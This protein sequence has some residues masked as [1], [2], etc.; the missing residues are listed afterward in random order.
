MFP[1]IAGMCHTLPA[2]VH[3]RDGNRKDWAWCRLAGPGKRKERTGKRNE[4]VGGAGSG[5]PSFVLKGTK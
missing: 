2:L 3:T 1:N 4:E 5:L